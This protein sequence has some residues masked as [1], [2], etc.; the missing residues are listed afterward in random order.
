MAS[1]TSHDPGNCG[2]PIQSK[3]HADGSMGA[4]CITRH[5]LP[6][7]DLRIRWPCSLRSQTAE[8]REASQGRDPAGVAGGRTNPRPTRAAGSAGSRRHGGG[9]RMNSRDPRACCLNSWP[10]LSRSPCGG[11]PNPPVSRASPDGIGRMH[12]QGPSHAARSMTC[13][14]RPCSS[15]SF[16]TSPSLCW[17]GVEMHP[18]P[19]LISFFAKL[20]RFVEGK[21][22]TMK[23]QSDIPE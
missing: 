4:R 3:P 19:V 7:L 17:D 6:L 10:V 14:C 20:T 11:R 13:S 8:Q 5:L 15:W 12:P 1:S 18:S 23:L 22:L 9:R 2:W 16:S 21:C